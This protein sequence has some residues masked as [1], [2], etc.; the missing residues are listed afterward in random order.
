MCLS[1]QSILIKGKNHQNPSNYMYGIVG[2]NREC[3]HSGEHKIV[4]TGCL[5][6]GSTFG[7]KKAEMAFTE[8]LSV[9]LLWLKGPSLKPAS[10]RLFSSAEMTEAT[11][12]VH[13]TKT[14]TQQIKRD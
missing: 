9:S 5:I 6:V 11:V 14:V 4:L 1:E 8:T 2:L 10:N 13:T 12:S 7:R 3:P